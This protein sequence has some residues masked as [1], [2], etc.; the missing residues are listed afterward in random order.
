MCGTRAS[1][2]CFAHNT[3][4]PWR[5]WRLLIQV[6]QQ[7]KRHTAC[8][9]V[10]EESKQSLLLGAGYM[11]R[12]QDR[13]NQACCGMQAARAAAVENKPAGPEQ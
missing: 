8:Y 4:W 13:R 7:V 3:L 12:K 11:T 1:Y 9:S 10:Q 2:V 6:A 5:S